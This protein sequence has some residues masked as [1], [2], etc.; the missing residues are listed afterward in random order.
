VEQNL[1]WAMYTALFWRAIDVRATDLAK[2]L[3]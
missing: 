1:Q 2:A 3:A